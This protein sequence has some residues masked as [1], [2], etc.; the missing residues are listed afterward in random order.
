MSKKINDKI[1][2]P[3]FLD[4]GKESVVC[5]GVIKGTEC[6]QQFKGAK[7]KEMHIDRVCSVFGGKRCPHYR[8]VSLL[9][10]RGIKV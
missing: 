3:F 9:Y 2:C 7:L 10:E 5:E 8:N 1:E 4:A 6:V